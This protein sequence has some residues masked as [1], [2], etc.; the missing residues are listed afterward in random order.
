MKLTRN[1]NYTASSYDSWYG[2]VPYVSN[3]SIRLLY[4]A[5]A[6][7]KATEFCDVW[8]TTYNVITD[9]LNNVMPVNKLAVIT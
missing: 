4:Y 1:V 5:N 3:G 2:F 6:M 7:A 8:A 9:G